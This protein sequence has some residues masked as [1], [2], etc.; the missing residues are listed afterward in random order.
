ML[1]QFR[2]GQT[3]GL[4]DP[5]SR[6]PDGHL[7]YR[8][9][10]HACYAFG[11]PG[12]RRCYALGPKQDPMFATDLTPAEEDKKQT[13]FFENLLW[14]NHWAILANAFSPALITWP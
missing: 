4:T 2:H 6:W 8:Q 11:A 3:P 1:A 7:T 5:T 14:A 10:D 9:E 12:Q 13:Q